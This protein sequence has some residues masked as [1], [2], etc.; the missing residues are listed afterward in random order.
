MLKLRINHS[1]RTTSEIY[2]QSKNREIRPSAIALQKFPVQN[3]KQ[4]VMN[5]CH[6]Q[7]ILILIIP[8]VSTLGCPVHTVNYILKEETF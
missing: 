4:S 8:H 3:T 7:L 1:T 6:K 2:W 5:C